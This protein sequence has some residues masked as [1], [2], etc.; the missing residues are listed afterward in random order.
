MMSTLVQREPAVFLQAVARTCTLDSNRGGD[1]MIRLKT[2]RELQD[3]PSY[4]L[5]AA[6]GSREP[7]VAGGSSAGGAPAPASGAAASTAAAAADDAS[8]AAAQSSQPAGLVTPKPAE[9]DSAAGDK[10]TASKSAAKPHK[11]LVPGN[12]VEVID[13]LLDVVMSYKGA[14][15]CQQQPQP[16]AAGEPAAMEL[17]QQSPRQQQQQQQQQAGAGQATARAAPAPAAAAAAAGASETAP[18]PA[19]LL[20]RRLNPLARDVGIQAMVLRMLSDYCLLYSNT[21]GLLLKRDS[22]CGPADQRV[23][24]Q[25]SQPGAATAA[26]ATPAAPEGRSG[27][28]SSARHKEHSSSGGGGQHS[29][30]AH[31]AG[32]VLQH[33]MHVQ[34]VDQLPAWVPA[35]SNVAANASS[36]LQAV[37]IRSAEG[38]R[39][40]LQELVATLNSSVQ[41]PKQRQQQQQ[42]V[43]GGVQQSAA[44]SGPLPATVSSV[45]VRAALTTCMLA[46]GTDLV[47]LLSASCLQP[48]TCPETGMCEV[49]E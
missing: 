35:T 14:A 42:A 12:F 36:L 11:K 32:V 8:A 34:L 29:S 37:C 4:L 21:V 41:G 24:H 2:A 19:D 3:L 47:V 20:L 6:S 22:E 10:P 27:R 23:S 7:I 38:R 1:T 16:A 46:C 17:D 5:P 33:I 39:R 13:A 26:G 28:R 49:R 31:K 25:H 43:D 45:G 48:T 40:I 18:L 9:R 44:S 15:S 30:D